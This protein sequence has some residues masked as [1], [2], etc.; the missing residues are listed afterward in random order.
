MA[1]EAFR[2]LIAVVEESV[3]EGSVHNALF[4]MSNFALNHAEYAS[5][6]IR[7]AERLLKESL[8]AAEIATL[9]LESGRFSR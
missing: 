5:D 4:D 9:R 6:G 3:P 1:V 2:R 8:N 7:A